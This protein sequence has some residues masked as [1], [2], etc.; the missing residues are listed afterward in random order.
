MRFGS[1][2]A[3]CLRGADA[4]GAPGAGCD[5]VGAAS[6]APRAGQAQ[7]IKARRADLTPAKFGFYLGL[8]LGLFSVGCDSGRYG[9]RPHHRLG[10]G[11]RN[12]SVWPSSF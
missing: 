1:A 2:A 7:E 10:D 5:G 6:N 4:S 9:G 12:G 3:E 8:F 11:V